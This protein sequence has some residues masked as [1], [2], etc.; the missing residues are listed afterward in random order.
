M[1]L[2]LLVPP[3]LIARDTKP[4]DLHAARLSA[5]KAIT[6]DNLRDY[7]TFIASDALQG[8]DTP[9]AGLDAAA[10]FIAFHLKRWG[11][12]PAGDEGTYFQKIPV[13]RR[14]YDAAKTVADVDGI[15]LRFSTEFTVLSGS[16]TTTG[17]LI[18]VPEEVGS[19]D[20]KGK[21]VLLGTGTNPSEVTAAVQ[22]GASGVVRLTGGKQSSWM[23]SSTVRAG[24]YR[25]ESGTPTTP[26]LS[27]PAISLSPEAS[28]DLIDEL[29][30][31]GKVAL[32]LDKEATVSV[33][34]R[35]ERIFTQNVVG[36]VEGVDSKL[37]DEYVALGAHYDHIGM[38]T[39][40]EG[41]LINN[42]ADDD[43]SGTVSILAI[44]EAA[45]KA[46]PKRSLLFVWH[47]GEEK[48]MWGS[49]YFTDHPTVPLGQIIT[50]LNIDMV[51]RSKPE[52]DTKPAN[53]TLTAANAIYVIGTTMM[54]T[55][56]GKLVQDT[57]NSYLKI[58]YDPRY[59]A[60]DD[61]NRFFFRSDHY[62]YA[63]KGI[64][65]CFWFD[66]EHEDYHRVGDE[67]SKIDFVKI[68][69]IAR[70]VFLTAVNVGNQ[71]RR[72]TVDKPLNR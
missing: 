24:G 63:R 34:S 53:R 62:S 14:G 72:P 2:M 42:G 48:G 60:P 23:R 17:K 33:E 68:E 30:L 36:I 13:V 39:S 7:L 67:V 41:D 27:P 44:A 46:R 50:Q 52:G 56:L 20:V 61:P 6:Q 32:P 37:K 70:T 38:R 66:G 26:A 35:T 18:Y 16:G 51:G 11:V 64:P 49:S 57:N 4:A 19:T 58:S 21:V 47:C 10:Q 54:S 55:Q 71:P 12:K 59:D 9:S 22:G 1:P 3:A 40:G 25:I 43:G 15:K 28:A 5:E 8:R 65:I 45:T 69:K 31:T 29:K